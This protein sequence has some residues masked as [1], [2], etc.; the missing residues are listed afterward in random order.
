MKKI[1]LAIVSVCL[2]V[3]LMGQNI[4]VEK[5]TV[6]KGNAFVIVIDNATFNACQKQVYDYAA[7]ERK[8]ESRL[9]ETVEE[10]ADLSDAKEEILGKQKKERLN[11]EQRKIRGKSRL[12]FDDGN[13]MVQ[14]SGMG[15]GRKARV[16]ITDAAFGAAGK[17]AG[18]AGF[19]AHAKLSEAEDEN[20]GTQAAHGAEMAA[21]D[22]VRRLSSRR[23]RR[24]SRKAKATRRKAEE[25]GVNRFAIAMGAVILVMAGLF[26]KIGAVIN[27]MPQPVLGGAAIMMFASIVISGINLITKEPL[28]G[29]NA[30]IVAIALGLGFGVGSA[31]AVQGFM[32]DWM[33]YIFGGSGIV[34]AAIIAILLN[35]LIPKDKEAEP[36]RVE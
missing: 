4:K 28:T 2:T 31:S 12:S 13:G 5:P 30:T 1:F 34:P 33:K 7:S 17:A 26:P 24:Q 19:A 20:V 32:P 27:I 21:E 29:R 35:I 11:Q 15:F 6:K 3:S 25:A 16:T 18:A 14:G 8:K 10:T 9:K 22:S 23:L 36:F